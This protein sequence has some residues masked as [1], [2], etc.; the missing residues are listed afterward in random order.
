MITILDFNTDSPYLPQALFFWTEGTTENFISLPSLC[1]PHFAIQSFLILFP[2]FQ[3]GP[4]FY[5]VAFIPLLK[6]HF[7]WGEQ[8]LTKQSWHKLLF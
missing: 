6:I 1:P 2:L 5:I 7:L 3:L 8:Y 4:V